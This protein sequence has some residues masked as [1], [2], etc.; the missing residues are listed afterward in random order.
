M[1]QHGLKTLPGQVKLHRLGHGSFVAALTNYHGGIRNFRKRLGQDQPQRKPGIWKSLEFTIQQARQ[2]V[3]KHELEKLPDGSTLS[4]M[5]YSALANAIQSHHGG[6]RKFRGHLGEEVKKSVFK[7]LRDPVY[8]ER[9]AKDIMEENGFDILPGNE[10]LNKLGYSSFVNSVNRHHGGMY[11]FRKRIGQNV[12]KLPNGYWDKWENAEPEIRKL[13][14]ELGHF[15][16]QKE[17]QAKKQG[18]LACAISRT[19]GGMNE[20]RQR[21]GEH[22]IK[23][24]IGFY[25]DLEI[26]KAEMLR[27]A[28]E[29]SDL[30]GQLPSCHWLQKNGYGSLTEGI[31]KYHGGFK[32]FREIM[33][34]NSGQV[35]PGQW[36]NLEYTIDRAIK[37][38]HENGHDTL[39][40]SSLINRAGYSSLSAAIQKYH[41]GIKTFRELVHEKIKLPNE[42]EKL[43]GLLNTYSE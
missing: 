26:V 22:I 25:K 41:G 42:C 11:A 37:F 6:M 3:N 34:M 31:R 35:E 33:E 2:I 5:G 19:H 28:D 40:G 9:Q 43:E 39:P 21:M 13:R 20:V 10:T 23:K 7:E 12:I 15:P 8:V 27:L 18:S 1:E 29:I 24:D 14:D 17:L 16:N 32:K 4:K 36:K 38:M 30:N